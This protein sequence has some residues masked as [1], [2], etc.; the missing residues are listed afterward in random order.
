MSNLAVMPSPDS[1]TVP[2]VVSWI[3]WK[4]SPPCTAVTAFPMV[5]PPV[6]VVSVKLSARL[7]SVPTPLLPL[8]SPVMLV[9]E[10][11]SDVP[12]ACAI[13]SAGVNVMPVPAEV[14]LPARHA[15]S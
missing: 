8:A 12:V 7:P 2:G 11:V 13:V 14:T 6:A 10:V 5:V 3:A 1:V 4:R 9:A 15:R